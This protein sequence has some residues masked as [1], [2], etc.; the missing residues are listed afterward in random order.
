MTSLTDIESL[1]ELN[2]GKLKSIGITSVERLLLAG[3]QKKWRMKLA[4]KLGVNEAILS[5]WV[6]QADLLRIDGLNS[7][8]IPTLVGMGISSIQE[9]AVQSPVDVHTNFTKFYERNGYS[10]NLPGLIAVVDWIS[11]ASMLPAIIKN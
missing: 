9:L 5:F 10:S 1:D 11:K 6:S 4:S 7:S 3:S 2:I 8:W